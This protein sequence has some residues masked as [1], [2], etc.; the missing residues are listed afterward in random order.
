MEY[1]VA[2]LGRVWHRFPFLS[3][4]GKRMWHDDH[5]IHLSKLR[6]CA[7]N[8]LPRWSTVPPFSYLVSP[9]NET[10]VCSSWYHG[11]SSR[12]LNPRTYLRR[13]WVI[14]IEWAHFDNFMSIWILIL[15]VL[16]RSISIVLSNSRQIKHKDLEWPTSFSILLKVLNTGRGL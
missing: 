5:S 3:F 7:L 8:C 9:T 13:K 11:I 15:S 4:R 1:A 16:A 6:Q 2:I 10:L 14:S 12:T